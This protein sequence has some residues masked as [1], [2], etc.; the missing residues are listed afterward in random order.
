MNFP[1]NKNIRVHEILRHMQRV[2]ACFERRRALRHG[3]ARVHIRRLQRCR[4]VF[5]NTISF[6]VYVAGYDHARGNRFEW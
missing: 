4:E 2:R 1:G 6:A 3:D 5:R